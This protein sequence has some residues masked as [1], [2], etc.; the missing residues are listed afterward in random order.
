MKT[1]G[2]RPDV[3]ARSTWSD[4]CSVMPVAS[5]VVMVMVS[6]CRLYPT[7][8]RLP[9]WRYRTRP[10]GAANLGCC[11]LTPVTAD[12]EV[13]YRATT[14]G[15]HALHE[16]ALAVMPGGTTR[17]TTY[18]DPY[19][20]FIERGE[21]CR[22]WDADGAERI[23]ML[24]NYTAMILGHAHPKVVEAI[25]R[26]AARGTGFAAANP[27]EVQLATLLCERVPSLAA[28]RFCN[29]GTEAT[30]FAMRLARAFT[31][32]PKI[33]R[34]EGGYHGTHDYAEVSTHPAVSE[35]GPP[36]APIARPD[37]TGT[38]AWVLENTVLLPFNHPDAAE[39]IIRREGTELAAVILEPIIGAGGV[40]PASVDFLQRLRTL[41]TEL[42]ILLIFDEVI[43][44]RVAPGG[45]QQM[46][47]VT[48]DLTT[49]G[50][51]IGGGLPVAAFGGRADVMELL[52]PRREPSLA[53]G[54]TYNGNPLGMAAG[55]ATI[56]ELTP[57]VY[58]D[59]NRN[60]ARGAEQLPEVFASHDVPVQLNGAGS[61]FAL[62]FTDRPVVDY[63][64][65]ASA[66][67]EMTHE[68]FLGLVNQGVLI[69]PRGM[70]ALSTAMDEHDIQEFIDAVDTVV[71]DQR[72]R[73]EQ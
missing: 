10:I 44:L 63:R 54:G 9:R 11:S 43:S 28:V 33:A 1:T 23:D 2:F 50:K 24:G 18:I 59:L 17:T 69:A 55:L 19:P 14:R 62:H 66:N 40:I 49:M 15:S 37:S 25:R 52:D 56:R 72:P 64:G 30:M 35:A 27:V 68:L 57:D 7:R 45:A 5:A 4:S 20:L 61:M 39:A 6:P 51:I 34:M 13:T 65:V 41:T 36:H 21:G 29:S 26:Q 73:W 60:G 22:V 70:G 38:P 71:A 12:P 3:F 31:G 42:G 46:Y 8:S 53:Q 47:G 16:N 67:K 48:P 58:E 32:R